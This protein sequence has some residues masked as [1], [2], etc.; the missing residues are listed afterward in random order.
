MPEREQFAQKECAS[1]SE[2][3]AAIETIV[4]SPLAPVVLDLRAPA[5]V[6][7]GFA[8]TR[9][10]VAW[11]MEQAPGVGFCRAGRFEV[12]RGIFA[13]GDACGKFRCCRRG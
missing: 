6:V 4:D 7:L 11:Q 12:R 8:G 10:D 3:G 5:I 1:L 9:E 2:A 13:G